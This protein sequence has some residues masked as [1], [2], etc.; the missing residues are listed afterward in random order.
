MAHGLAGLTPEASN[1][2]DRPDQNELVEVEQNFLDQMAPV[3]AGLVDIWWN[4]RAAN[5]PYRSAFPGLVE[6]GN[7]LMWFFLNKMSRQVMVEWS[8]EAALTVSWLR[9]QT[10]ANPG[11]AQLRQLY[12]KLSDCPDFLAMYR[13]PGL[14]TSRHKPLMLL[15]T[16]NGLKVLNAR[17]I[18]HPKDEELKIFIAT[19]VR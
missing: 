7:I 19:T 1:Q 13:N 18:P 16:P 8:D 2:E 17:L 6:E 11:S 12:N 4:V 5:E 10:A 9:S 14:V 15:N 3:L